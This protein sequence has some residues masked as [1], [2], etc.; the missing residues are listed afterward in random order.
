MWNILDMQDDW[1]NLAMALRGYSRI[2]RF[3]HLCA[4][5]NIT[6]PRHPNTHAWAGRQRC[7]EP[8]PDG[9]RR[10]INLSCGLLEN[11]IAY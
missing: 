5:C 6:G 2:S 10:D 8:V 9:E 3:K 4:I 11:V 1:C 7:V